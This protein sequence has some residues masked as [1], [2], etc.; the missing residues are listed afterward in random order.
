MGGR[1]N[2]KQELIQLEAFVQEGLTTKQIAETL[3]RSEAGI[4][5]ICYRKRLVRKTEDETKLL[6][7]QRDQLK[8]IVT[9]IQDKKILLAQKIESLKKEKDKLESIIYAEKVILEQTLSQALANLKQR[10]PDLF[11]LTGQDQIAALITLFFR[12]II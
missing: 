3:G 11:T 12:F 1:R 8:E 2:T 5:N 4:R 6:F 7:K 9:N 10:R